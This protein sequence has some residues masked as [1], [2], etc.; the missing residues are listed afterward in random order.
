MILEIVVPVATA[1]IMALHAVLK[2]EKK[3]KSTPVGATTLSIT[4]FH[5]ITFSIINETH[6]SL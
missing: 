3:F 6:H 2:N 4:A 5:K 1:S